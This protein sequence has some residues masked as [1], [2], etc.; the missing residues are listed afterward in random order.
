MAILVKSDD[1]SSGKKGEG[2][3]WAV[4]GGTRVNG[5]IN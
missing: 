2:S 4:T 1:V 3:Q 5:L